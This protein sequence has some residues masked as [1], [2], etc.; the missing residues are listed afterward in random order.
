VGNAARHLSNEL[1]FLGL[2]KCSLGLFSLRNFGAQFFVFFFELLRPFPD[3]VFQ[4]RSPLLAIQEVVLDLVL[5]P[6]RTQSRFRSA[7]KGN[8]PQRPLQKRDVS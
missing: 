5:P 8:R 3:Q 2:L 7:Y 4:L 6:A 1:H